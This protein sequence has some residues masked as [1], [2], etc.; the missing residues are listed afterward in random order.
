[1]IKAH[2]A[3]KGKARAARSLADIAVLYRAHRQAEQIAACLDVAGI[4]Y[5][6]S[7]RDDFL[8]DLQVRLCLAFFRSLL[9]KNDILSHRLCEKNFH[10]DRLNQLTEYFTPRLKHK[11]AAALI[12]EWMEKNYLGEHKSMEKLRSTALLCPTLT[13]LLN[14]VLWGEEADITRSGGKAYMPEA[15]S[16][17][18]LHGAK[19]LEFPVVFLAGIT[20]GVIP[21]FAKGLGS[22]IEEEKRLLYVGMTRAQ[23][24]LILISRPE[25][26]SLLSLI[27]DGLLL[28]EQ[29]QIRPQ[30]KT[31]QLNLFEN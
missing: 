19:G 9:D 15:V 22:D 16:L 20:E 1:M 18:T 13:D 14:N 4:P 25:P 21:F 12:E 17:M 7:G 28:R 26:S 24:E 2:S 23:D 8:A 6:V 31:K 30:V 3:R 27:P 10:A 29:A 5:N 11:N